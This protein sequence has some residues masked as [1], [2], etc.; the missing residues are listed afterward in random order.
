MNARHSR[1]TIKL[2]VLVGAVLCAH[3]APAQNVWEE[4]RNVAGV[5]ADGWTGREAEAQLSGAYT[6]GK[7]HSPSMG[8][9]VWTA[10]AAA[11]ARSGFKDLYLQGNFGFELM[12]GSQM[13]GSMFTEPGYFPI[14]VV[15]FT[16]GTKVKQTYDIG[17]GL[18][19]RNGSR[20]IPGATLRFRGI[21]YAKRKDLRHTTYRQEFELNPS[22]LYQG[23]GWKAGA[24][25]LFDK[26]SEYIVAEQIGE[27][28]T[29]PYM[30]FLDK[31]IRYGTLQVWDGSG[32][33]LKE[34]G[35][36]RLPV[37][38]YAYGLSLQAQLGTALYADAEY[39][40]TA[41]EVGEK[42]YTWFR[43][44]GSRIA[45]NLIWTLPT[46][47]GV[48][49]LQA[50]YAWSAQDNHE[51]V[52]EK[53]TEG[54]V[55]TPREYGSNRIFQARSFEA[56]PS[57]RFL[58]RQGWALESSLVLENSRNRST[59]MYPF[60]DYDEATHLRVRA[61]GRIPFGDFALTAGLLFGCKVGEHRHVVENDNE[62]LGVSTFPFRLQDWWDCDSEAS[63]VT[64]IALNL[65]LRYNL[66]RV[67]HVPLS[68]E[69]GCNW[70]HAFGVQLL[71]GSNRQTTTLKLVYNY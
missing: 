47:A 12:R 32:T 38:E 18:A 33:H 36:D 8:K 59:L 6:S 7:F 42:G 15:E 26:T 45:A 52:L 16:P 58:H 25:I 69:A 53:V 51:T 56:G 28:P 57:W 23:D 63:D 44:P 55:T 20:W 2:F 64:R 1:C 65:A 46:A 31:G 14:D 60:L 3:P 66:E 37:K 41:G 5:A 21:N 70:L 54:G 39:V 62:N 4:G 34:S 29:D 68:V 30:A 24:T 61:G 48:H 11:Q 27:A 35:V 9:D 43:F 40:R 49:R 50:H 13:M 67:L 19:L 10:G 71:S 17:G 22:V